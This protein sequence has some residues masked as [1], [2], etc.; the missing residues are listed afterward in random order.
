MRSPRRWHGAARRRAA[1]GDAVAKEAE[2]LLARPLTIS[3]VPYGFLAPP[4]PDD[5]VFRL[6][7]QAA[8]IPSFCGDGMAIALHSAVLAAETVT[9][10]RST[11]LSLTLSETGT[12]TA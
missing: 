7:D 5:P 3:G 2:P 9:E 11:S 10:R 8:V 6:G 12:V 1:T 4:R